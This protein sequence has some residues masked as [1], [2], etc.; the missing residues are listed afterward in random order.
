M[1]HLLIWS[2]ESSQMILDLKKQGSSC[3]WIPSLYLN[4]HPSQKFLGVWPNFDDKWN[5]K[6]TSILIVPTCC[7]GQQ[8]RPRHRTPEGLPQSVRSGHSHCQACLE[9]KYTIYTIYI[10]K[11]ASFQSFVVVRLS[12]T[13][14]TGPVQVIVTYL[15]SSSI[16]I[17]LLLFCH[18]CLFDWDI[19]APKCEL[20]WDVGRWDSFISVRP[21]PE[22]WG[23]HWAPVF[24]NMQLVQTP[25]IDRKYWKYHKNCKYWN[26]P[27]VD[28]DRLK[29]RSVA[30]LVPE[31][32][33]PPRRPDRA[34]VVCTRNLIIEMLIVNDIGEK[35]A[36]PCV[37]WG[38]SDDTPLATQ[39]LPG[40]CNAP[41]TSMSTLWKAFWILI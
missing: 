12:L 5:I 8:D 33:F 41:W 38:Q 28:V 37:A 18:Q 15:S 10:A 19:P 34:D 21:E 24:A 30:A 40:P 11:L 35:S 22:T 2:S 26:E 13:G 39:S 9:T 17:F 25:S 31:V 23:K 7:W 27:S 4:H 36:H 29:L 32:A 6:R 14:H 20:A 3:H 1:I 16:F